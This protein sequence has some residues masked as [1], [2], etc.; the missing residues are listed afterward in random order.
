MDEPNGPARIL[1]ERETVSYVP[2]G[3][4]CDLFT[5]RETATRPMESVGIETLRAVVDGIEDEFLSRRPKVLQQVLQPEPLRGHASLAT[6]LVWRQ[7]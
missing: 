2:Q 6:R 4:R 7:R 5:L 3:A 1:A